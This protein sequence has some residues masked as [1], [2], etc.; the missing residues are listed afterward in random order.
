[1]Q[2]APLFNPRILKKYLNT[3]RFE[4]VDL[5]ESSQE[6][7]THWA[8]RLASGVIDRLSESQVEQPFNNRIF[9]E[10]LG[11]QQIG[12]AP[13]AS[14]MPKT[15]SPGN[16]RSCKYGESSFRFDGAEAAASSL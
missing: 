12:E 5:P 10:L 3:A 2:P 13:E 8:D 11:Y 14:L 16:Y 15:R 7:V 4:G 1:M 9:G 6:I